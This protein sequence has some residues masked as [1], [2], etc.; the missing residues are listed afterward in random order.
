[1]LAF[2]VVTFALVEAKNDS[3][4]LEFN[5]LKASV[6]FLTNIIIK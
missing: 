4:I 2:F 5:Y 1:M 3:G 6:K